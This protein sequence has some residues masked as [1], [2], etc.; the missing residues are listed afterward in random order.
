MTL[1]FDD[2]ALTKIA[3]EDGVTVDE[4]TQESLTEYVTWAVSDRLQNL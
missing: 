4:L 3:D 2:E 1:T